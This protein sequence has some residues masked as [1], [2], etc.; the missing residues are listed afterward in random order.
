MDHEMYDNWLFINLF[1]FPP[2]KKRKEE[3]E[4]E[5]AKPVSNHFFQD[6]ID[7]HKLL[8]YSWICRFCLDVIEK[9]IH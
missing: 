1:L 4:N 8:R 9:K 7:F 2:K 5:V 6:P 3:K